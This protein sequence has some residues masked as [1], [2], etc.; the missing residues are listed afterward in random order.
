MSLA[1]SK[2]SN[3]LEKSLNAWEENRLVTSGVVRY[4]EVRG[5]SLWGMF[6][7]RLLTTR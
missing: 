6:S 3:E 2:K 4:K 5:R 7:I 1:A